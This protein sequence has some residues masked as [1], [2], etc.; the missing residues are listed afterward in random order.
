MTK[1]Q[2]FTCQ[3]CF[4]LVFAQSQANTYQLIETLNLLKSAEIFIWAYLI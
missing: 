1:S 3:P 4:G 2:K